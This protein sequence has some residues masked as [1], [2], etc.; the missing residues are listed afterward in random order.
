LVK[1]A[2]EIERAVPTR[3]LNGV[4][5][6]TAQRLLARGDGWMV[7]DV[8]CTSGPR[9]RPFEE[10]HTAFEIAIVVAGTFQYRAAA[11][12]HLM[13]P[14][15]LLLGRAGDY[16]ECGHEHGSGDRCLAFQF[17]P[18]YFESLAADS[19][20]RTARHAFRSLRVPPL[21][22]LSPVVA[23]AVAALGSN[24]S[25]TRTPPRTAVAWEEIALGLA[26][27]T[28]DTLGGFSPGANGAP[29]SSYARVTRAVRRIE[30]HIAHEPESQPQTDAN[31][32]AR[33]DGALSLRSLAREVG[34]S[35]FH[36]LRTFEHLTGL[37]PHQYIR[38]ARLREAAARLA[39]GVSSRK[40]ASGVAPPA[41]ILDIALD[42]G[43]GDVSNFN[44]AFRAEFGVSPRAFRSLA[45]LP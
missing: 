27:K 44:H 36:F 35:P 4:P 26:A 39:A 21:R 7:R 10:Q 40:G 29:P 6:G 23:C 38:R 20:S 22:G 14:G 1:I 33:T 32:S 12:R 30:H 15:S 13:T 17:A 9:D 31:A 28:F 2:A 43:F 16:F 3:A 45:A 8:V 42:S 24:A 18:D 5:G 41:R 34:L 37:T 11:G 19:G 25:N